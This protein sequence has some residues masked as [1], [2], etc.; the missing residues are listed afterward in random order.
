MEKHF[1]FY[2]GNPTEG[3][4]VVKSSNRSID[5]D[6][7]GGQFMSFD[8]VETDCTV[9]QVERLGKV[10]ASIFGSELTMLQIRDCKNI[11]MAGQE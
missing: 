6:F 5:F 11:K 10:C 2:V 3:G 1:A 9:A 7:E 8:E 4:Q